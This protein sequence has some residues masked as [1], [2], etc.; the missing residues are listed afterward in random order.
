MYL[1]EFC[2]RRHLCLFSIK[3]QVEKKLWATSYGNIRLDG[4]AHDKKGGVAS[5]A[6]NEISKCVRKTHM[7]KCCVKHSRSD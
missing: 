2:T 3:S 6:A 7:H 1:Y 4:A 5:L